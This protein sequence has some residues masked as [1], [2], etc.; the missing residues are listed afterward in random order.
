MNITALAL[1]RPVTTSMFFIAILL[2]GLAAAKLLPLELFP[3]IEIPQ[4][5]VQVPYQGSTPAEVERDITAILEE[6]LA[7][8]SGIEQIES[9]SNQDGAYIELDMKWGADVTNL[10]LQIREK[11]DS[12]QHLLPKDVER[13]F[14][15]QFSTSDMPVLTIRLSSQR[16]LSNA[17][18]LLDKQLK[19]PLERVM[20]VSKVTLY[21]V[22]QKQIDIRVNAHRLAATGLSLQQLQ[23][24]LLKH[25]FVINSGEIRGNNQII[26]VSPQGEFKSLDDIRQIVIAQGTTLADIADVN[27]RLPDPFEG[28]HLDQKFAV[29]WMYLKHQA[30]IWLKSL[31][32]FS[33]LLIKSN[34]THNLMAL[35]SISWKIKPKVW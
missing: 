4:I 14:I 32:G 25:N 8:I 29:D 9:D 19:R 2:F 18:D 31:R 30:P 16:E 26:Q 7:T 21:G 20:G 24:Y 33:R 3:G 6:S 11:I 13:I 5:N 15:Q 10:S 23:Q 22:D 17:F 12:V 1:K 28:R 27:Y 35:S 34:R